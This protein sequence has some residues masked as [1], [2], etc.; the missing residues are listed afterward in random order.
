MGKGKNDARDQARNE[1]RRLKRK[2][3]ALMVQRLKAAK[4]EMERCEKERARKREQRASKMREEIKKRCVHE[5][6]HGQNC[7]VEKTK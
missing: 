4:R 3:K 2:A 7:L 1:G 5:F 6:V